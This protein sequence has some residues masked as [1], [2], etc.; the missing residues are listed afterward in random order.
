MEGI[1][2]KVTNTQTNKVYIGQTTLPLKGRRQGHYDTAKKPSCKTYFGRTLLKYPIEC[3]IWEEIDR[4]D[5]IAVLDE[6]ER[7]W[8]SFCKS[9]DKTYGYNLTA[10][11]C[12]GGTPNEDLRK[13]LSEANKNQCNRKGCHYSEEGRKN[14]SLAQKRKC[15]TLSQEEMAQRVAGLLKYRETHPFIMSDKH[16]QIIGA[17]V[18]ES[19]KKRGVSDITRNRMSL[20]HKGYVPTKESVQKCLETKRKKKALLLNKE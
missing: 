14:A 4:A 3:F 13:R 11:G 6:K 9:T 1:I 2:Y 7:Y 20:A 8:I 19:N 16:K 12:S 18:R 10:G 15:E 17:A 5:N